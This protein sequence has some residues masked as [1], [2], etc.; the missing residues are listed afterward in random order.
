MMMML[1]VLV[2][3]LLRRNPTPSKAHLHEECRATLSIISNN[4]IL[5]FLLHFHSDGHDLQRQWPQ[6]TAILWGMSFWAL[7]PD[8]LGR[9]EEGWT[10]FFWDI[11]RK[12]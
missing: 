11:Y 1:V 4:R 2:M 7:H 3:A 6:F 10:L 5:P 9:W 12:D 8:I